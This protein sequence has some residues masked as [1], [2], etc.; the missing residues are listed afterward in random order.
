MRTM[1]FSHIPFLVLKMRHDVSFQGTLPF[2]PT[3]LKNKVLSIS[4]QGT[5]VEINWD[6][7]F[8]I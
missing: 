3:G 7:N 8:S 6:L 5:E 4:L 1:L 2:W